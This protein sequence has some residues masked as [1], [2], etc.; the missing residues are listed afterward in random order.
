LP[1][2]VAARQPVTYSLPL[3]SVMIY[4]ASVLASDSEDI[5][6]W[7]CDFYL[8]LTKCDASRIDTYLDKM[9]FYAINRGIVT[10]QDT[11]I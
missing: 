5:A 6:T 10:R 2:K 1:Y 11:L 4:G 9:S 3:Y 7:V 8:K